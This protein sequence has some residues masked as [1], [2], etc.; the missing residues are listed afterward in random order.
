M[1]KWLLALSLVGI[2]SGCG[3]TQRD[4]GPVPHLTASTNQIN[5]ETQ[6]ASTTQAM[7]ESQPVS[8]Q[9]AWGT[10]SKVSDGNTIEVKFLENQKEVLKKIR[11]VGINTPETVKPGEPVFPYGEESSAFTKNLLSG[12][13]VYIE[14]DVQPTDKFGRM[15]GYVYLHEPKTEAEIEAGMVNA[16]LLK[17]GYAQLMTIPP[18]VKYQKFFQRLQRESREGNKCLWALNMYLDEAKSSSNVFLP[19]KSPFEPQT[20]DEAAAPKDQELKGT[21]V[22]GCSEPTIKGNINSKGKKLYHVKGESSYYEKT[23]AEMTFCTEKE[24]QQAGF[25]KAGG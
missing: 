24:A 3:A 9:G 16:I 8:I 20:Q 2:I 12:K 15:L 1:K 14:V 11:L 25:V 7:D 4:A 18:N 19:G 13:K 10:V 22:A 21:T 6:N 17:E 23:K 5:Q